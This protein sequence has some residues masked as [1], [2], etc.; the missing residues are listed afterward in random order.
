M[1]ARAPR[2][3]SGYRSPETNQALRRAS[4][5]V[6]RN[7]FHMDGMAIDVALP[8]RHFRDIYRAAVDMQRGGVGIY[9]RTTYVHL[10]V[11]PVRTW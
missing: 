11:D 2:P 3:T 1:P 6:A 4:R 5:K 9:R 10:D 8:D 7:S